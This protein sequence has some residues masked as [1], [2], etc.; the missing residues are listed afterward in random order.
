[1][2]LGARYELRDTHHGV[3]DVRQAGALLMHALHEE[4]GTHLL[5]EIWVSET[6]SSRDLFPPIDSSQED[7]RLNLLAVL[8]VM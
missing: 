2:S 7:G 4:S 5:Q 6:P 1:M 3:S 8:S